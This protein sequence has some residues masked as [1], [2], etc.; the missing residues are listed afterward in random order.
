MY[1]SL[2]FHSF[3]VHPRLFI[4]FMTL[5][6][7]CFFFVPPFVLWRGILLCPV[8]YLSPESHD[9]FVSSRLPIK[10][11]NLMMCNETHTRGG[12]K[13]TGYT[14]K[15]QFVWSLMD[16][17]FFYLYRCFWMRYIALDGLP[18]RRIYREKKIHMSIANGMVAASGGEWYNR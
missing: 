7:V 9:L 8:K 12:W 15:L 3:Q 14:Q 10:F 13:K 18:P 5:I 4:M 6:I 11:I 2:Y 1:I 17:P 16:F